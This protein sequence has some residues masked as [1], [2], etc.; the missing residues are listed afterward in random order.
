MFRTVRAKLALWYTALFALTFVILASVIN[1]N[2]EHTLTGALDQTLTNETGWTIARVESFTEGREPAAEVQEE[3]F[4]RGAFSPVKLLV[5]IFDSTG[6]LFYRSP[7]LGNE[8]TLYLHAPVPED[9]K[10]LL[11]TITTFHQLEL[12]IGVQQTSALRMYIATPTEAVRESTEQLLRVFLWLGPAVI[13]LA[14]ASGTFVARRSLSKMNQVIN[15]AQRITADRL[16]DRIPEHA[17]PDEIGKIVSTFNQMISRLEVSFRQMKQFSGDA[18]HELRTPL[19]V[20]R[21]QLETALDSKTSAA[22][23]KRIAAHCLDE[24]LLMSRIIDNLLLLEKGDAGEEVL[25]HEPVDLRRL[26]ELT[27]EESVI[28]ASP[29]SI[30]VPL[31]AEAGVVVRGDDQRLRQM[32]L[33]LIDNAIKYTPSEGTISLGLRRAGTG[34]ELS[35]TDDGIGIAPAEIP[36]IFDR[37]YRVDRARSRELGGAGLGLSIARWIVQAHGGTIGVKSEL[38]RGSRFTVTLPLAG[39]AGAT[40]SSDAPARR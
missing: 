9:D 22:E 1:A 36:R 21:T 24:T 34:A 10:L 7:N 15:I 16:Y 39:E 6:Q 14:L 37:F 23:I 28:L 13:V 38:G 40:S 29:K 11:T 32:L 17:A 8:D 4:E 27:H 2:F 18:S 3:L 35:V 5:E 20:I 31:E 25:R 26:V 33:N 19:T 30:R 12:R